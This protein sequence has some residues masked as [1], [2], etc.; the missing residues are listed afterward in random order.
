MLVFIALIA[1]II[2]GYITMGYTRTLKREQRK[3]IGAKAGVLAFITTLILLTVT[4][5]LYI[6]A[7]LGTGLV[8][9]AKRL[10][11][12]LRYF[13][14]FKGLYQK[15]KAKQNSGSS[16][17]STVESSLLKMTLDHESGEVDG[18]LLDTISK[19]KY[20]SEFNLPDLISLY[21]LAGKQYPDSI[22]ILASY[23]DRKYGADWREAAN[24]GNGSQKS[25]Q[26][27]RGSDSSTMSVIEA[28]AVLGLDNNATQKEIIAAHRKLM[29]KLHPDKGGSNYLAAKI[30][31]AKDLLVS[32]KGK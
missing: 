14:F 15:A 18:E 3:T 20:L 29:L 27:S 12:F 21:T 30:N 4:G 13:P 7:A 2:I 9:F 19:G 22:E 8:V 10:L 1:V 28:Y 24:A 23:L 5:K 31:Q 17:H 26:N 32:S 11:P 6:L 16:K 25:G